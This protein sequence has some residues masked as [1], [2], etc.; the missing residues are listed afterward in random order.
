M[1]IYQAVRIEDNSSPYGECCFKK[2]FTQTFL[3]LWI[4]SPSKNLER[5]TKCLPLPC[6]TGHSSLTHDFMIEALRGMFPTRGLVMD[7]GRSPSTL[8]WQRAI[9]VLKNLILYNVH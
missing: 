6:F 2:K 5:Y 7:L 4:K 3:T 8:R 9:H 1:E